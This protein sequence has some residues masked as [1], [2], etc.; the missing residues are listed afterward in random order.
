MFWCKSAVTTLGAIHVLLV[1][2]CSF[3]KDLVQ[4]HVLLVEEC[5]L[6][7]EPGASTHQCHHLPLHRL[8]PR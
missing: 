2:L 4:V 6:Y 1:E 8:P 3:Y 7:K 5:N